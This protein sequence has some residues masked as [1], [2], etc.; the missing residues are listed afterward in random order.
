MKRIAAI[1]ALLVGAHP[2]LAHAQTPPAAPSSSAPAAATE[3]PASGAKPAATAKKPP[4]KPKPPA[5]RAIYDAMP[6]ADRIAIQ[7]DLMW[8]GNYNGI[9]DGDFKDS[10]IAAVKAWQRGRGG[11]DTGILSA[12]E[13]TALADAAKAKR[14]NVGWRVVTDTETGARLGL[15]GK[16][17]PQ[18]GKA[19]TGSHWQSARGEVQV[20]T[21]RESA[22][23]TLAAVYEQQQ[24]D[25]AR[26]IGYRMLR[27]DAF[28]ISGLQ[29]LK[30]FYMRAQAK[31]DELR[32][33]VIYYDQAM[34]GIVAPVVIA[35]SNT[36]AAFPATAQAGPA[37]KRR[38]EYA[39]GIVVSAGGNILTDREAIDGC[40]VVVVNGFG[41]AE[42]V[43]DD[44]ASG[45]ALLRLYGV[46]DLKPLAIGSPREGD[47]TLVGI[48]DPQL[49]A[50]NANVSAV[51][52]RAGAMGVIDPPPARGF[53]GAA[54][55]DSD[56]GFSGLAVQ[57]PAMLAAL[58]AG[59]GASLG[60]APADAIRRFLAAHGIA[61]SGGRA[62]VEFAKDSAVRV[63]C[64]RK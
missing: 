1:A 21:F 42:R 15:P 8:T 60:I 35:M 30:K 11:K 52:A 62:S 9:A 51:R 19:K 36:F 55:I 26:R 14:D 46:R 31:G 24:K 43:A 23:A 44:A 39:T 20:D 54:L 53:A 4:P 16:L 45:L 34:E 3:A 28:V 41:N 13:R 32:G 57:K 27:P 37:P 12:D 2:L 33:F 48:A 17:V 63:I 25:P 50:G 6:V 59:S 47:G 7:S 58:G 38:V 64:V 49:Q 56:G 22:P 5:A 18:S 29:G 40:M 10:S 61:A